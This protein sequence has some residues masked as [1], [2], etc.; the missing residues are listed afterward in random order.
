MEKEEIGIEEVQDIVAK[1]VGAAFAAKEASEKAEADRNAE[2]D[3]ARL[4]GFEAGKQEGA[5]E[6]E[7]ELKSWV[8]EKGGATHMKVA[9]AG[10]EGGADEG[11][12]KAFWSYVRTG[13]PGAAKA[14]QEGTDC[15]GGYLVP[16]GFSNEIVAKLAERSWPRLAGVR[17]YQHKGD[18]FRIPIE[19]TEPALPTV[20]AEEGAFTTDS[21]TFE[22]TDVVLYKFTKLIKVA[23]ELDED[24]IAG[25]AQWLPMRVAEAFAEAEGKYVAVGT[26]SSQP[27][28]VFVGGTAGLTFDSTGNITADEIPELFYKLQ[29]QYRGRPSTGWLMA[30]E[31]EGYIRMIRDANHFAFPG[32]DAEGGTIARGDWQLSTLYSKPVFNDDD[33]A[34]MATGLK[35]ICIGDFSQYAFVEHPGGFRFK[36]L[37]ELYSANGQLGLRWYKRFGGAV[38]QAEA[39]QYGTMA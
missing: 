14:L 21:P 24:E 3:S 11:P 18:N 27:Q 38:L 29:S 37:E 20:T 26:G 4:E 10:S 19:G 35:V 7:K 6:K 39:F 15:E 34:S 31:V 25:M 36:R 1:A 2:L 32:G 9:N 22:V 16:Q 33:C 8:D 23:E 28:G 5:S 12:M 17:I 30:P 13:D